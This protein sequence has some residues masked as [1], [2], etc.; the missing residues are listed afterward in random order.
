MK[1]LN[2]VGARPNFI[3]MAPLTREMRRH[4]DVTAVLVDTG[5][6]Y[7]ARMAG[8]FFEELRLP[9]PDVSLGVGSGSHAYQT[10]EVM[11]RLGPVLEEARPDLV[12]VVGDVN[13]T[14]AAALTASKLGIPVAHVEAGLRSF[15]PTMPEEINRRLTDALSQHLFVT[16]ESGRRNLLRE[17]HDPATIHLVGNVM[18]DCLEEFRELWGR[19]GIHRR[20]GLTPDAYG[21]VTLHRPTNVDDPAMLREL[22]GALV[23]VSADL[24]L[25]FPL[26][27]RTRKRLDAAGAPLG[28]VRFDP[29]R[30]AGRGLHCLEPLGY[31]DFM[32]LVASARIV[33]TDS[34]GLQEETTAL[35]VPCLT[36]REGTERPV[37]VTDGTNRIVGTSAPVI[38]AEA[39][40]ALRAARPAPCRPPGWDGKASQRIVAILRATAGSA[41]EAERDEGR[42]EGVRPEGD[43]VGMAATDRDRVESQGGAR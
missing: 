23:E 42:L 30:V 40:R 4:P 5:Q 31:L 13:S 17:G 25:V 39:Q 29:D 8:W 37:T 27:P 43:L 6:H 18:I 34:G 21:V 41:P 7:E 36:L 11:V 26:H 32:S 15:V 3:K 16:E 19:S 10:A 38:V 22:I 35:G 2:V 12:L 20:L 1:I 33:L 14:L 28:P 24:P 9:A